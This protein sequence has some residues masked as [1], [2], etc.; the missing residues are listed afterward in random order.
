[1]AKNKLV[2]N[3][4]K[5]PDEP[6]NSF[7]IS[8]TY[9]NFNVNVIPNELSALMRDDPE[10]IKDYL[11]KEQAHRHQ[12][13]SDIIKHRKRRTRDKKARDALLQAFCV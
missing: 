5:Q 3:Q 1:M 13:E 2:K 9:Q 12:T 8:N 4:N 10:F 7:H 11:A 6:K